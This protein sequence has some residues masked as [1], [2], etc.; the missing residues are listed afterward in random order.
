MSPDM[1]TRYC[2][3]SVRMAWGG[4]E[5]LAPVFGQAWMLLELAV[6]LRCDVCQS[7]YQDGRDDACEV[8]KE[9]EVHGDGSGIRVDGSEFQVDVQN[10]ENM[11]QR[12]ESRD[13]RSAKEAKLE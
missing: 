9:L 11:V 5:V 7:G 4:V 1:A 3:V 8:G 13:G 12:S 6:D 2:I 10:S